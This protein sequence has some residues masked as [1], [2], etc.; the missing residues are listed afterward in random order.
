MSTQSG[1]TASS[2][3]QEKFKHVQSSGARGL[4][5]QIDN[6]TCIPVQTITGSDNLLDDFE[7]VHGHLSEK[8]ARYILLRSDETSSGSRGESFLFISFVP[9]SAHVRSKMLYA[10]SAHTVQRQL[11]GSEIFSSVIFWSSLAEVSARGWKDHQKHEAALA[12]LSEEESALS[13]V[14][15]KETV[16]MMGTVGRKSHYVTKSSQIEMKSN[17]EV[18]SQLSLLA[19]AENP[20]VL[21]LGI[22]L[23][24]ETVIVAHPATP[25][26]DVQQLVS[27]IAADT[28][29]YTIWASPERVTFVYTCPMK[30]KVKARMVY[31]TNRGAV[32]RQVESLVTPRQVQVFEASDREDVSSLLTEAQNQA[33]GPTSA[34]APVSNRSN[35]SFARPKRPGRK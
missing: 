11:G 17:D 10:S 26:A 18:I 30:S 28:P 15:E 14:R 13:N 7:T 35:L 6:E 1:I 5:V 32:I 21:G 8:E 4:I 3:L 2:E 24:N 31:A 16:E 25:C 22:D 29:Q 23:T 19:K 27:T 33:D 34:P 9:D 20:I 12:P